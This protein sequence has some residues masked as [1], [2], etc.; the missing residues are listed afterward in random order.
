MTSESRDLDS[1]RVLNMQL[2]RSQV[3]RILVVRG[4]A[5]GDFILTLPVFAA[6]RRHFPKA[7]LEVLGY[8]TV[9]KLALAGGLVDQDHYLES[10]ALAGFFNQTTVL[11]PFYVQYLGNFTTIISYLY[12][13]DGHFQTN[14]RRCSAARFIQGS[15]RPDE[16]MPMH[17]VE[18]MLKPLVE[19]NIRDAHPI[20]QLT[21]PVSPEF[22]LPGGVWLGL[23][24]GS[25]SERKNWPEAKW[26]Q[27]ITQLCQETEFKFLLAGG[28]A[29]GGRLQRL[30]QSLP[31][32]RF[33]LMQNCPLTELAQ[34]LGQCHAYAGHDS[35]IS[36]LA[37]A[38]GLPGLILWAG[39]NEAIWRPR[40]EK[41]SVLRHPDGLSAL[42]VDT[43]LE[44]LARSLP[45]GI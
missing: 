7:R 33:R 36:H 22:R 8:P 31:T 45:A 35:G 13:P 9:T 26:R 24:P 40:S 20:P 2:P 15:H 11:D 19:L 14:V 37:A 4:G 12:D 25:G 29:E 34:A 44:C 6:L 32:N 27:F 17:A 18:V 38:L 39:S 42:P 41:I 5:I 28:E 16:S 10:P 43:V 30:T 21:L 23:H 3:E 1:Y